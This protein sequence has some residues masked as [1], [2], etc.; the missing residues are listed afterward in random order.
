MKLSSLLLF[1]LPGAFGAGPVLLTFEEEGLPLVPSRIGNFYKGG[2]G[3]AV[4]YGISFFGS[5]SATG[6]GSG[7]TVI[8][9]NDFESV[10]FDV[11]DSFTRS[12]SFLYYSPVESNAV[13]YDRFEQGLAEIVLPAV[14]EPTFVSMAFS[15]TAKF[16][17]WAP[18]PTTTTSRSFPA[19]HR[20]AR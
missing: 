18:K 6:D 13:V 9:G 17:I 10:F 20:H 7:N 19:A 12:F 16:V 1:L 11:A 4:N 2:G 3:P 8:T 15:G 14:P 5:V